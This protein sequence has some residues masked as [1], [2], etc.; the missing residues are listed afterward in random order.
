MNSIY[1]GDILDN[2][3]IL[4]IGLLLS[5]FKD[6]KITYSEFQEKMRDIGYELSAKLIDSNRIK[7]LKNY[8]DFNERVK[9][10]TIQNKDVERYLV[11]CSNGIEFFF[12]YDRKMINV[13][14]EYGDSHAISILE[15]L[16][17]IEKRL[18]VG[19]SKFKK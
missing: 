8:N 17:R 4:N 1:Y 14:A 3:E 12:W 18:S 15:G 5:E 9:N 6:E 16:T 2:Q 10:N 13:L 7:I 11:K 19:N